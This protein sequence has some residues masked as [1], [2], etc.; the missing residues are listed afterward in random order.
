MQCY[1]C[2]NHSVIKGKARAQQIRNYVY[3]R[4]RAREADCSACPEAEI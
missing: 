2:P 4:Y 1:I 3:D